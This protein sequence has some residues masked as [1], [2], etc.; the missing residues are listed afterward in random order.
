LEPNDSKPTQSEEPIEAV[1]GDPCG[2]LRLAAGAV[3]DAGAR[4]HTPGDPESGEEP[5]IRALARFGREAGLMLDLGSVSKIF[6]NKEN[7]LSS[8]VEHEVAVLPEEGLVIKDYDPRLFNDADYPRPLPTECLFDY[9]TDHLLANHF[10]GDDIRLKGFYEVDGHI[11]ILIT[12]PFIQGRHPSWE[13]LVDDLERQG[14]EQVQPGSN[15]ARFRVDG[16]PAGLIVVTDVHE[17]NVIIASLNKAYPID[18]HF[19]F[20]NR[21]ARLAALKALGIW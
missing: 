21:E 15:K 6:A 18:V 5:E 14:L 13:E 10:F 9:L 1:C 16:G 3:A 11:H 12:Q 4:D 17:D 20:P 2:F 7:R 8:G 19:S